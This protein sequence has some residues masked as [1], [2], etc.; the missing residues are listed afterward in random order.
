MKENTLLVVG[1]VALDTVQTPFGKRKRAL[2]GSATY[3]SY[4]ASIF[5]PV[6]IVAV[7]G[8]DFPQAHIESLKK[9][10][11]DIS[12]LERKEGKTF[13]WEGRYD[14]DMNTAH[15]LRTDLNVFAQ[16]RPR[17]TESQKEL[18]LVFLANIDPEIQTAVL[19]EMKRPKL[20]AAD[21]MNYWIE[22]KRKELKQMLRC[23]DILLVNDAEA[24]SLGE[25]I[26]LLKASRNILSMGPRVLVVKQGEYGVTM[27][28]SDKNRSIEIFS[29]PALRLETV[30][31]PTG[32][33]DSFAGGFMAY[34]ATKRVWDLRTL[35][36]AVCLGT[37]VAS[38]TVEGFSVEALARAGKNKIRNRMNILRKMS[39]WE[40]IKW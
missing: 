20:V 13:H 37:V 8:K 2:G 17:L 28:Y 14:F 36:S 35:R 16:F 23:I 32:A 6:S 5:T 4:A 10:K 26:N 12:G 3:F 38:F 30:I 1:S 15:T 33:G 29:S 21:T 24:R 18:P 25:E 7:V 19:K 11:I 27:F 9:R 22:N 34:L 40:E 39:R 31:D